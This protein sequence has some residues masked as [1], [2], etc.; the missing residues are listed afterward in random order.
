MKKKLM[1]LCI[2]GLVAFA[3]QAQETEKLT[4]KKGVPILPETGDW[5]LGLDA[6]PFFLYFGNLMNMYGN[7]YSPQFG[8]TA[9]NPGSIH[10]KYQTTSKTA[11]RAIILIGASTETDKDQ[12]TTG[13]T[14]DKEI[15]S[16]LAI[17]I[18]LGIEKSQSVRGRL[19]GY[20]GGMV[21]IT[22]TPYNDGFNVGRYSYVD[23]NNSDADYQLVGGNTITVSAG[24]FVGVEYFFAPKLSIGGEFGVNLSAGM[25]GKRIQKSEIADDVTVD[26]GSSE[27]SLA[28]GASGNLVLRIYL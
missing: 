22:K 9:Q 6:N 8:F 17:G 5:A 28:N 26:Y 18:H 10:V 3:I 15:Y 13:D 25:Q 11:Y 27:I 16:A 2:A 24:G 12:P 19:L 21:G 20:Y 7:T 14:P 1:F 23:A 4:S